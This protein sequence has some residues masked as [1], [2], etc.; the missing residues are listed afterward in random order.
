MEVCAAKGQHATVAGEVPPASAKSYIHQFGVS[1]E[2]AQALQHALRVGGQTEVQVIYITHHVQRQFR[3]LQSTL[4]ASVKKKTIKN[5]LYMT[6][7]DI[8]YREKEY[9]Y[10]FKNLQ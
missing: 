5:S 7:F 3:M 4:P 6:K 8:N 1:A 10:F 2:G 9:K